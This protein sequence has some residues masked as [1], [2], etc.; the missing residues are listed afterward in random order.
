MMKALAL[1]LSLLVSGAAVAQTVIPGSSA[2]PSGAAGGYLSGTYPNPSVAKVK[3]TA[4]NDN[5]AAGDVGEVISSTLASGSAI[6]LTSLSPANVTSISLTAGD[7]DVRGNISYVGGGTV[8]T[9]SQQF[10]SISTTSNTLDAS[11]GRYVAQFLGGGVDIGSSTSNSVVGPIRI[12]LSTTTT[13]YLVGRASFSG[14]AVKA[15]GII[16]ARRAR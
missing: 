4:T 11:P 6:T 8:S 2:T 3:G 16:E 5:A 10:A 15:F 1:A 9:L 14:N 12:S 7:W 13:V